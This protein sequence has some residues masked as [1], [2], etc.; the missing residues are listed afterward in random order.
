MSKNMSNNMNVSNASAG[1]PSLSS[2]EYDQASREAAARKAVI[3]SRALVKE[4]NERKKREL[5]KQT[6]L[7]AYQLRQKK[8]LTTST[9]SKSSSSFTKSKMQKVL[10]T[11]PSLVTVIKKPFLAP[12]PISNNELMGSIEKNPRPKPPFLGQNN[13]VKYIECLDYKISSIF[14][15]ILEDDKN[16]LCSDPVLIPKNAAPETELKTNFKNINE[17]FNRNIQTH[18]PELTTALIKNFNLLINDSIS[19]KLNKINFGNPIQ[20]VPSTDDY[21]MKYN[22]LLLNSIQSLICI[23]EIKDIIYKHLINY[24]YK[25]IIYVDL[26]NLSYGLKNYATTLGRPELEHKKISKDLLV[27]IIV[28]IIEKYNYDNNHN[29]TYIIFST[30][31]HWEARGNIE[32]SYITGTYAFLTSKSS[33]NEI[34]DF[35]IV[36]LAIFLEFCDIPNKKILTHNFCSGDNYNWLTQHNLLFANMYYT[37]FIFN[38]EDIS[39]ISSDNIQHLRLNFAENVI[40]FDDIYYSNHLIFN[41]YLA[42]LHPR[43]ILHNYKIDADN[44]ALQAPSAHTGGTMKSSR[45]SKRKS[46]KKSLRKSVKKSLRKYGK[47]LTRKS[48]YKK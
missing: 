6:S 44:L 8:K 1:V 43:K 7:A 4:E 17:L 12:A 45:K 20:L 21:Y 18:K 31:T 39:L 27:N 26:E 16:T 34:D 15:D 33:G 28:K 25:H 41:T 19:I 3:Q 42:H 5:S 35:N 38:N 14:N 13:G 40:N 48:S 47:K 32:R 23:T 37:Y 29:K 10:S 30:N 24:N 9:A 22:E 11:N 46:V 36:Y 2:I